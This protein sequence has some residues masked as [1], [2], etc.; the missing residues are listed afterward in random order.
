MARARPIR[1]SDRIVPVP[2]PRPLE[3]REPLERSVR[4]CLIDGVPVETTGRRSFRVGWKPS[5]EVP[6]QWTAFG[7]RSERMYGKRDPIF[8]Y[9]YGRCRKCP[10]CRKARSQMWQIRAMNEFAN[11][12]VTLFG[13]ITMSLEEHYALDARIMTGTK[14][15]DGRFIRHPQNIS[16][17][18]DSEM[19]SARVGV[20]GDEVQKFLKRLR[21]GDKYHRPVIR[22]L[23]VAE[24]H[25]SAS[26]LS[27]MR[28]RPHFHLLLHEMEVGSLVTGN[29]RDCI[30]YGA[31]GEYVR[32]KYKAGTQW[33]E[34]V[35]V[36]DDAFLRT[37]WHFGFTKFQF[38]ENAK[39][40]AY[41]CKYLTKA[42][43]ERVRASQNYGA[44]KE[45]PIY[46][47]NVNE[48]DLSS[49]MIEGSRL[50]P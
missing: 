28:G 3:W 2:R 14:G 10:A 12:P 38:A 49:R 13:T 45:A 35:F 42:S 39:A 33:R 41:L 9:G 11:C 1:L 44:E 43:D 36:H 19:F 30:T 37:Q 21:K 16:E 27:V 23:L 25:D 40:A 46:H 50:D 29:P 24:A 34:G 15:K 32:C 5:C 18:S 22:Y 20:F 47:M 26:T 48:T 7:S 4:S 31:S 6:Y 8:L 17:L